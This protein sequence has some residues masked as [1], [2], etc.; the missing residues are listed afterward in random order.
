MIDARI[1]KALVRLVNLKEYK[2][3]A[4]SYT[5]ALVSANG[6]ASSDLKDIVAKSAVERI[7]KN[8]L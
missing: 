6:L 3:F 8:N 5:P 7:T 1:D 2:R 4:A